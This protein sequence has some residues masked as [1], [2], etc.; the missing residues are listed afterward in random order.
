MEY[1]FLES[2]ETI[3]VAAFF[4]FSM[5]LAEIVERAEFGSEAKKNRA[6]F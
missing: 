6:L 1:P 2:F 4:N 3:N 5:L